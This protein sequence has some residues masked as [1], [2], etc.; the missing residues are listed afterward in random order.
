MCRC[1]DL[2]PQFPPVDVALIEPLVD[3]VTAVV[4]VRYKLTREALLA[5]D[6]HQRLIRP[7]QVLAATAVRYVR[8]QLVDQRGVRRTSRWN[9][10]SRVAR[11]LRRHPSTVI[12]EIRQADARYRSEVELVLKIL[13]A[14]DA[15]RPSAP[16]SPSGSLGLAGPVCSDQLRHEYP[17]NAVAAR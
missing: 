5:R 6:R 17:G 1:F 16:P 8:G 13:A 4:A 3:R 10:G 15:A 2:I 11:L 7:R 9:I 14:Q 12:Y